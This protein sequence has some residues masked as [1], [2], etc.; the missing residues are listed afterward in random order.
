MQDPEGD[1]TLQ[2]FLPFYFTIE[3]RAR[4]GRALHTKK[5]DTSAAAFKWGW[6]G[7]WDEKAK[8]S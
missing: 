5:A 3:F 7:A 2:H 4:E 6:Q 1:T 8:F